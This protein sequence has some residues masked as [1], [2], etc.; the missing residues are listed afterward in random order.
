MNTQSNL[1]FASAEVLKEN[2]TTGG[3]AVFRGVGFVVSGFR[4]EGL[5]LRTLG[6]TGFWYRVRGLGCYKAD[7][8]LETSVMV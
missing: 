5:G 7:K 8:V 4:I 6:C 2:V 3:W 1:R